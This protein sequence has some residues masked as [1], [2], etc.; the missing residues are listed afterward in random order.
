MYKENVYRTFID[1][2][3]DL[4]RKQ[5]SRMLKFSHS[6]LKQMRNQAKG[7]YGEWKCGISLFGIP[8]F[9]YIHRRKKY[10]E[11]YILRRRISLF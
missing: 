10:L 9:F 3:Q 7:S 2:R 11:Q 5:V 4:L 6:N 8:H 1:L